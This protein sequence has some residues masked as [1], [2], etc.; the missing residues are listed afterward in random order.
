MK[1]WRIISLVLVSLIVGFVV[2][3]F[4][5]RPD[6]GTFLSSD[7]DPLGNVYVLGVDEGSDRYQ[8]S[9]I[10]NKGRVVYQ[11]KLDKS[12]NSVGT[13]YR[14]LEVDEKGN[15]YIVRE[16][17]DLEAI[18]GQEDNYPIINESVL[19]FDSNGA[20]V[21][22][23][24]SVD[25]K[26]DANPPKVS[27]IRKLQVTDQM[28]TIVGCQK[29]TYNIITA[30][31]FADESP[32]KVRSFMIEP[33]MEMGNEN[34]EWINDIAVLSNNRVVYTTKN[35]EFY[36]MDNQGNFLNYTGVVS[37]DN[38]SLV[39]LS[40]DANDNLYFS[41]AL[42]GKFYKVNT[43][44]LI[45]TLLYSIDT[46]VHDTGI[47]IADLRN[48]QVIGDGDFYAASKDFVH[49]Y[50]VRF[51]ANS[52]LVSNIRGTFFPLGFLMMLGIAGVICG[53]VIGLYILFKKGIKRIPLAIKIIVMLFPVYI[54]SMGVL[55]Y[56]VTEDAVWDYT[57]VL[58]N[59]QDIGAKV[60][61]DHI[62]GDSF[63]SIDHVSDY[64]TS[65]YVQLKND[66]KTGYADLA[67]K[68]GDRS[69]YIVT[70]VVKSGKIYSTLN[71]KYSD[72]S[73]SYKELRYADPDMVVTGATAVEYL[74]EKDE[75]EKLYEVWNEF[76]S[77]KSS[78]AKRV[79][80]NDIHGNINASFAAIRNSNGEAVGFVGNFMD[81]QVHRTQVM[82][83]ILAHSM[84]VVILIAFLVMAY[85]GF[86]IMMCLRHLKK[87]EQGIDE[88]NKGKWE[89]RIR[90]PS[91]DELADI[92]A[93]FNLMAEK[94]GMY[95]SNLV[96]LNDEYVKFVPREVF[97]L[98]DKSKITDVKLRDNKIMDMNVLY[99]V[100][101]L[102]CRGA[103]DF[104]DEKELFDLMSDSYEAIFKVV[105][106][107]NG[108]IQ[109]FDGVKAMIF[110]PNGAQDSF[111]ASLQ[112][113]EIFINEKVRENM[114]LILGSGPV[115]IGISGNE[116]RRGVML[117]SEEI[118]QLFNID[119]H[120]D[121]KLKNMH[122]DHIAT[123][124]FIE[125][126]G[127]GNKKNYRFIGKIGNV[128]GNGEINL[129]QIIDSINSYKR[130]LYV[131]T[132]EI[133]EKAVQL[134]ISAEFEKARKLFADVARVNEKDYVALQYLDMCDRLINKKEKDDYEFKKWTGNLFD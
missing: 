6:V 115:L 43:K 134:Y 40:V 119:S 86:V 104:K 133:F 122:V 91:K 83:S 18:V 13:S 30:N 51:G 111:N 94:M 116:K 29:Y 38:I 127:D 24:A 20:Y 72:T 23:V 74:L 67:S 128:A 50:H 130:D 102:S 81:E 71:S 19:M 95:T 82:W 52:M 11:R 114:N 56:I 117:I 32:K 68:I 54:L 35:G 34:T 96:R 45:P 76:S 79:N 31:P 49:P 58:L 55:V 121:S 112:F 131:K 100:F 4:V 7:M 21:K 25:F 92:A 66:I 97:K 113:K 48:I 107:N 22:D 85:I 42:S 70:Y 36:A 63:A 73:S 26:E 62:N 129:Y 90:V 14:D 16:N 88:I 60:L 2:Q 125:K 84:A 47:S 41:D 118:M 64:M 103:Y 46:S 124:E 77:S 109:Y 99:V 39:A 59:D 1:N 123:G 5:Y 27:Y 93:S 132:K 37:S 28:V 61:V 8:I 75:V 98:I 10:S 33:S 105:E 87:I 80:F 9:K 65:S 15:I 57:S 120:I 3:Y 110:F 89:T 106:E 101:N 12:T 44:S 108:I 17:R 78:G 53:S 69:D 126:L